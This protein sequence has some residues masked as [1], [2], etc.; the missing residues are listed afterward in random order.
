[1][2]DD[3]LLSLKLSS[4]LHRMVSHVLGI[5]SPG[6]FWNLGGVLIGTQLILGR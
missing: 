5:L 2:G 6:W 1:M 3:T 4:Y